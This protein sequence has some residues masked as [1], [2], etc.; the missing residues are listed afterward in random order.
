MPRG[1]NIKKKMTVEKQDVQTIERSEIKIGSAL[2]T[3][4][5]RYQFLRKKL[6]I[7]IKTV[8]K[9]IAARFPL[10]EISALH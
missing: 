3:D 2:S 8:N 7:K 5:Q 10:Q 4:V 9:E 1:R 6:N